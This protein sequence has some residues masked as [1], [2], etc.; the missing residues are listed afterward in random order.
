[1]SQNAVVTGAGSGVGQALALALARDGWQ[2]AI[3][4]RRMESL[5]ETIAKAERTRRG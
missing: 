2:V 1:M 5:E 3:V 4:G